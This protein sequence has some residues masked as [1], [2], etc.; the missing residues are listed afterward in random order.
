M[1][2]LLPPVLKIINS[3][4]A[5]VDADLEDLSIGALDDFRHPADPAAGCPAPST[6]T[7]SRAPSCIRCCD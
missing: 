7:T 4:G 6:S 2:K 3:T 5:H 1:N